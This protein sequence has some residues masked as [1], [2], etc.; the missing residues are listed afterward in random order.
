MRKTIKQVLFV[1]IISLLTFYIDGN[2]YAASTVCSYKSGSDRFDVIVTPDGTGYATMDFNEEFKSKAFIEPTFTVDTFINTDTQKIKCYPK[3]AVSKVEGQTLPI[4]VLSK[5]VGDIVPVNATVYDNYSQSTSQSVIGKSGEQIVNKC[6]YRIINSDGFETL[7]Y[8]TVNGFS[9]GTVRVSYPENLYKSATIATGIDVTAFTEGCLNYEARADADGNIKLVTPQS[10]VGNID[11]GDTPENTCDGI[12][13]PELID[14][15][16]MIFNW[17]K[18]IAP[19]AVV[20][21]SSVDFAGAL[22]KD[23]KDAL[24][25]ASSKLIKRLIVAVALFF[26]PTILNYL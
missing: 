16:Q 1:L 24:S 8:L 5:Q 12:L 3:I 13:G 2:V 4:Y 18:I 23:D 7:N 25:K 10:S 21:L 9:D 11:L 14:F 6:T 17:I 15:F 26:I 19:I 22:L 20:I